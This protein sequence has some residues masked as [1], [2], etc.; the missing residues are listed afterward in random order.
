[1]DEWKGRCVVRPTM[2]KVDRKQSARKTEIGRSRKRGRRELISDHDF[3][4]DL[5]L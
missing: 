3:A 4:C 5:I 2:R 1:M